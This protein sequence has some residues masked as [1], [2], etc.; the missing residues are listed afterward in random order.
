MRY[1]RHEFIL[2]AA[3][4]ASALAYVSF[5]QSSFAMDA[6]LCAGFTVTVFSYARRKRGQSFFSGDDARSLSEILLAHTVCLAALV[7]V[8]RTGMFESSLPGWMIVP[9]VVDTTGRQ[10]GPTAFEALQ[11]VAA[12][13]LGYF[14]Y[15]VLTDPKPRNPEK[16]EKKATEALWKRAALEAERMDGLRLP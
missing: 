5:R 14:E 13:S 9:I 12:L 8:F 11:V 1:L 7:M 16:E 2:L 10:L 3:C 4:A 6:T 15:R